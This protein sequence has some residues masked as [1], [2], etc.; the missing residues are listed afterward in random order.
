MLGPLA[1]RQ[2]LQARS[3]HLCE[4]VQFRSFYLQAGG[5][6]SKS[7]WWLSEA[8]QR[9][10]AAAATPAREADGFAPCAQGPSWKLG[11]MTLPTP[12][13]PVQSIPSHRPQTC[14]AQPFRRS[15]PPGPWEDRAW[16]QTPQLGGGSNLQLPACLMLPAAGPQGG[17]QATV[18]PPPLALAML[19][20]KARAH[21]TPSPGA[22][23]C[24]GI[25][26]GPAPTLHLGERQLIL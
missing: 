23:G 24:L 18:A 4:S 14:P 8:I 16:L 11:Q 3:R 6:G 15:A 12:G 20:G 1:L 21:Q 17:P 9:A 13:G 26:A 22:P 10:E 5:L 7:R 19:P 2:W 25:W